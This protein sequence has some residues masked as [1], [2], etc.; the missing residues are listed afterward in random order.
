MAH[1]ITLNVNDLRDREVAAL[2]EALRGAAL[3]GEQEDPVPELMLSACARVRAAVASAPGGA[4]N[5]DEAEGTIPPSLKDLATRLVLR[6]AKGRLNLALE[7]DEVRDAQWD[8]RTLREIAAGHLRVE[9]PE[10]AEAAFSGG[11]AGAE[12]A[13]GYPRLEGLAEMG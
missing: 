3:G 9:L 8:E 5:L 11:T 7:P 6:A 10:G 2:V 12:A 4:A 13:R 1:W